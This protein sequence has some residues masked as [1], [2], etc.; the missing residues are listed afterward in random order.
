MKH[1]ARTE[2]LSDAELRRI[3]DQVLEDARADA[4]APAITQLLQ[5]T[6]LD[7][8]RKAGAALL[9]DGHLDLAELVFRALVDRPNI[10][11][12][13]AIGM[14]RVAGLRGNHEVAASSW[15]DCLNR[16]ADDAQP[17]W[18]ANYAAA[19][20][21]CGRADEEALVLEDMARRFPDTA[22][23][24]AIQAGFAAR[25]EEWARALS[26]WTQCVERHAKD[27]RPEW[28]NGQAKALFGLWR[29]QE[30]LERWQETIEQFPNFIPAYVAMAAAA[31]ELGLWS[32]AR[33]CLHRLI[34]SFPDSV[35]PEWLAGE[36]KCAMQKQNYR[37]AD[38]MLAALDK[39]FPDSPMAAQCA[40]QFALQRDFGIDT[41]FR[42]VEDAHRR[43]PNDRHL[44]ALRV[45]ALVAAGR[46]ADAEAL[47]ERLEAG[48]NDAFALVGRWRIVMDRDGYAAIAESARCAVTGRSWA[49]Q[50]GLH[51]GEFLLSTWAVWAL[52]L[53]LVLFDDLNKRFPGRIGIVG[54]RAR[55]LIMLR[56]DRRAS[57]LI[58]SVP[59]LYQ[60]RQILELRAWAAA[61]RGEEERAKQIWR[62]IL[63]RNYFP[64]LHGA[65]PVLELLTPE[66]VTAD[67]RGVTAFLNVR[68]ELGNLPEFL[69]HHRQLGIRRFVIVDNMSTDG[70]GS[71]LQEQ[72]DVILYRTADDFHAAG[73]GMRWINVLIERHGA[74]GWCLYAD[75][76]ESFI[77]PGWE[78]TPISRLTEYL[79]REGAEGVAA[80][81]LDLFPER[82]FDAAGNPATHVDCRY[83]D[84]DFVWIGQVRTPYRQPVGGVRTRLFGAHEYLHKVALFKSACGLHVGSHETTPLR[85]SAV[86]GT[87]FH[88]KLLSLALKSA[89][90]QQGDGGNPFMADRSFDLMRRYVRYTS[91]LA[92]LRSA[93]L[94]LP[95]V[96][97]TVTDSLTLAER[98]L[99]QA[100][101]EFRHW[102]GRSAG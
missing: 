84:A 90:W 72:P 83:Y 60:G 20:W 34:V 23:T 58:E 10:G 82:L 100:P 63:R 101:P 16:F 15:R 48:Q 64:A 22:E 54:H 96:S 50:Q 27:A 35:K 9:A 56:Q 41:L 53:A 13:V 17:W 7:A 31:Q 67:A 80:Y 74:G 38:R 66:R 11:P 33:Q 61:R 24:M 28:L 4:I 2:P 79:D 46:F 44:S 49:V 3:A 36:A 102:L 37:T 26:L 39:R 57:E 42:L 59:T 18:F 95:G 77:Y 6:R 51:I 47:V 19:L 25:R 52:E 40:V 91:H 30:A 14:A 45:W 68:N 5:G 98:G 69:R 85:M 70:G 92:T 62:A 87:L 78:W 76:D 12:W 1:P 75:C 86:T 81:M 94:R 55:A 65:D 21:S 88:Y 71:F 99:M 43:F 29:P 97:Q 8:L 32:R 89:N 93:D 73:S